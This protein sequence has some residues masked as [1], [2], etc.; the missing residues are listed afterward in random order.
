MKLTSGYSW[1]SD[2]IQL[3]LVRSCLCSGSVSC[4]CSTCA[5]FV[6][7]VFIRAQSARVVFLSRAQFARAQFVYVHV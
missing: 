7:A 5:Q 6:R 2:T 4:M 3:C 1:R